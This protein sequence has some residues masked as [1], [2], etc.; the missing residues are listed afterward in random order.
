MSQQVLEGAW[1]EILLHADELSG[2]RVRLIVIEGEEAA[3]PNEAM[4]SALREVAAIQSGMHP[5]PA[6]G[7]DGLL[8]EARDGRMYGLNS[9][10]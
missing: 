6:E 4:L 5:T 2:K 10:Q 9:G 8:R 3:S 1:E 7:S